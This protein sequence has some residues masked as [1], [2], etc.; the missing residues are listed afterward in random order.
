MQQDFH[1]DF[2]AVLTP[3][4][5]TDYDPTNFKSL[6]LFGKLTLYVILFFQFPHSPAQGLKQRK[7][8][9]RDSEKMVD[10]L[11][12]SW[13]AKLVRAERADKSVGGRSHVSGCW[14]WR[15]GLFG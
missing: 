13:E 9:E 12:V 11:E 3:V 4:R 7:E 2:Y 14:K 5:N 1:A 10:G 8:R 15:F 6:I